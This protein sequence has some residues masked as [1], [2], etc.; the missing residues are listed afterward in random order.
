MFQNES[1]TNGL[2]VKNVSGLP[3][4]GPMFVHSP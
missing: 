3:P 1:P 4:R 2:P